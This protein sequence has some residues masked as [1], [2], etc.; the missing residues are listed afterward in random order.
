MR[1]ERDS[2]GAVEVAD[3]RL[4]GAQTQRSIEHFA[5]GPRMPLAVIHALARVKAAAAA[6][7]RDLGGLPG[8]LAAAIET[9]AVEVARGDHDAHFPLVVYQTGSGTQSNMNVNE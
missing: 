5:V 3:D 7:N 9:A 1:I 8:E 2:M 6:V 4:W